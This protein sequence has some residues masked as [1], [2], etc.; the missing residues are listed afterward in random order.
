MV[1]RQDGVNHSP[2]SF[3]TNSLLSIFFFFGAL[4]ERKSGYVEQNHS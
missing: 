4:L 2:N 3:A 1:N